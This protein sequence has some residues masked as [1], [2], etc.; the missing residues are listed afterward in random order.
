MILIEKCL[1]LSDLRRQIIEEKN[2][3]D[4]MSQFQDYSSIILL[5]IFFQTAGSWG[6]GARIPPNAR[7]N[8]VAGSLG[9]RSFYRT[10]AQS[11]KIEKII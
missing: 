4:W 1:N 3:V 8:P 6:K 11:S 10:L 9:C 2:H 5:L 7:L